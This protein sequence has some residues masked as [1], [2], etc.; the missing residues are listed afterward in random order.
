MVFILY[1]MKCIIYTPIDILHK[2]TPAQAF[3]NIRNVPKSVDVT[4]AKQLVPFR[5]DCQGMGRSS[6]TVMHQ[7]RLPLH[8]G[9]E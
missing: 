7:L 8:P 6:I 1:W 4:F 9:C 5:F 3:S 2:P